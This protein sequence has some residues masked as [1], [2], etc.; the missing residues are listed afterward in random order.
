MQNLQIQDQ[1]S[2]ITLTV[3]V[4]GGGVFSLLKYTTVVYMYSHEK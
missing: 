4:C 2:Q 3:C 1:L